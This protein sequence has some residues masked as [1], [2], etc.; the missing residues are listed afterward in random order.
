[1]FST[2]DRLERDKVENEYSKTM[3]I[4]DHEDILASLKESIR[5]FMKNY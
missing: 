5:S 2:F 1:M 4:A 3:A